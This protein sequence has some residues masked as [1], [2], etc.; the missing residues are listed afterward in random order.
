MAGS[1]VSYVYYSRHFLIARE[2]IRYLAHCSP[3]RQET[4]HDL[5]Q[6]NSR[7]F[8]PFWSSETRREN[9]FLDFFEA[10]INARVIVSAEL[11]IGKEEDIN[12]IATISTME[13]V[14][15]SS[16]VSTHVH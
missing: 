4:S 7:S 12:G 10:S 2:G 14:L 13:N 15:M 11:V 6:A 3:S 1:S 16:H 5:L 9:L 8:L